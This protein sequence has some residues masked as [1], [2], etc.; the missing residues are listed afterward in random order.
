[1]ITVCHLTSA[2]NSHD[3]RIFRKECR[4]LAAN[5]Y[6]VYLVS[7]GESRHESGV[8]VVGCGT[9]ATSR[10]KRM[11]YGAQVVYEAGAAIDAELYHL[12]DPELLSY[13][14][15]LKKMGKFVIFDAHENY[16][17]QIL[18]KQYIPKYF[19]PV[20]SRLYGLF[21]AKTLREI[22]GIV[23]AG[24][25][26]GANIYEDK[27]RRSVLVNNSAIAADF[28]VSAS[29]NYENR[30]YICCTG[31]LTQE[32][33]IT[34]LVKAAYRAGVP[35]LLCGSIADSYLSDLKSMEEFRTARYLGVLPFEK[36][37][38]VINASFLGSAVTL[39]V[40][41]YYSADNL[42]TKATEY[43]LSAI[44]V[45]I[46]ASVYNI[47]LLTKASFGRVVRAENLDEFTNAISYYKNNP[48]A[49]KNAGSVGRQFALQH[50]TWEIEAEKLLDLYS[51]I[52]K[53]Q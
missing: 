26:N 12:H 35:L 49:V 53:A 22:D 24:L 28:Q 52:L 51:A 46:N 37:K 17:E 2:H 27:C 5:G 9:R 21:E 20:V 10:L 18:T 29:R 50:F 40:G 43:M 32:R 8:N 48:A 39:D 42:A 4:T 7:P 33:G 15:K 6:Q 13:A 3:N 31:S 25:V 16:R 45:L 19:R 44:P 11:R 30:K 14:L 38:D 23:F 47:N 34:Q 41:Q 1:M 36:V